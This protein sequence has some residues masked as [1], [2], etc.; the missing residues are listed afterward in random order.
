LEYRV[1]VR[2][3][4]RKYLDD[5][6]AIRMTSWI[7]PCI[8]GP[9]NAPFIEQRYQVLHDKL[10]REQEMYKKYG[11]HQYSSDLTMPGSSHGNKR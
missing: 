10:K 1:F 7:P 8:K 11:V 6:G 5:R 4:D 9:P 2:G 3:H